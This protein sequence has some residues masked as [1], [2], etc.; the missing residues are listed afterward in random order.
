MA[1]PPQHSADGRWWWDGERWHPA[2]SPDGLWRFDG[3]GWKPIN[4]PAGDWLAGC[5]VALVTH[6]LVIILFIFRTIAV[7]T[8]LFYAALAI[9]GHRQ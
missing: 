6:G 3:R 7:V 2:I 8:A 1:A 5:A 4:P 9:L